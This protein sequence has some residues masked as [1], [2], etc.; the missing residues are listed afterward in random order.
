MRKYGKP[1]KVKSILDEFDLTN[2]V[3][4]VLRDNAADMVSV[5]S[6]ELGI[7][8][9]SASVLVFGLRPDIFPARYLV[10]A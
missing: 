10:L 1:I 5:F 7:K 8:V 9:V 6:P 2:K 3:K 4:F